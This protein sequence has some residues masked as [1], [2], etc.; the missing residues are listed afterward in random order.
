[1]N[2]SLKEYKADYYRKNRQKFLA[3]ASENY[4]RNKDTTRRAYTI[5]KLYGLSVA[6]Y[7]TLAARQNGT[8]A[9]C[10][11]TPRRKLCVDHCHETKKV[12]GLLCV[13]CNLALGHFSTNH[14]LRAATS[15]LQGV[16]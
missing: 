1:M 16:L 12:R 2:L 11:E 4:Q 6:E 13:G 7:E 3:R 5:K 14:L 9:I 8:C 15:Y 10:K